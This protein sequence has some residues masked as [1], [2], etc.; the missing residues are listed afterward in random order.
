MPTD[1]AAIERGRDL[2]ASRLCAE[3]H[4]ADGEGHIFIDDDG[5]RAY[6]ARI[7]SGPGSVTAGYTVADWVRPE[8]HARLPA[9][10]AATTGRRSLTRSVTPL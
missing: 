2:F 9:H 4:G 7:S 1:A 6:G 8:G 10:A 3:C 5:L